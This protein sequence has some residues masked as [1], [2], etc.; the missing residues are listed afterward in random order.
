M[1]GAKYVVRLPETSNH[2]W[3][4][5]R[6]QHGLTLSSS[7]FSDSGFRRSQPS[8]G[9]NL[10]NLCLHADGHCTVVLPG[11]L[12]IFHISQNFC[13]HPGSSGLWSGHYFPLLCLHLPF[14]LPTSHPPKLRSTSLLRLTSPE[15]LGM[16]ILLIHLQYPL[17]SHSLRQQTFLFVNT[18]SCFSMSGTG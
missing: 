5:T 16:S 1:N 14:Y 12:H 17:Y 2:L 13:L 9:P 6:S 18:Q 15:L 8:S 7:M 4:W 3:Q 11:E 10:K